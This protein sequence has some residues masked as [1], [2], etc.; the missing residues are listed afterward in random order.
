VADL[1]VRNLRVVRD[2]HAVLN[3]CDAAFPAGER[4]VLW[5][6][7]GAGKSTLLG[8]VAGL[9]TPLSGTISLGPRV[10]FS[11]EEGIDVPPHA[12]GVGFVFQDLALWPHLTALD[13][14]RLVGRQAGLDRAG[15]LAVLESVGLAGLT[16]R[17]PGQ[18]SGGEQQRLAIA[19]ALAGKPAM[20]LLDEP[21]SSVDK[22]TRLSL[23]RLLRD[24][25]P[26]V[27]GPT[28][29]VTHD[30]GDA[31]S[32]AEAVVTLENGKLRPAKRPWEG[33]ESSE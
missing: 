8:A 18:L 19:R 16:S 5:G 33:A 24:I 25:S 32:L 17:R 4:T 31:A 30:A 27:S 9:L 14:V 13:Q 29:Y 23:R 15:A 26:G 10:L 22:E 1:I 12:R 3:A 7:S 2:G 6:R 11:G 28:I 20:L 21:F